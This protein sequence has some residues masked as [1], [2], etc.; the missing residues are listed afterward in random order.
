M[1]PQSS[2]SSN[3]QDWRNVILQ[4]VTI[5]ENSA[6]NAGTLWGGIMI[7]EED[8]FWAG[9]SV[10]AFQDLNP[11]VE[12]LMNTTPGISW[13]YTESFTAQAWSTGQFVAITGASI[14]APQVAT[15]YMLG[16][17]NAWQAQTGLPV[18]VTWSVIYPQPYDTMYY[19]TY[20]VTGS[21][22]NQWGLNL[23]NCFARTASDPCNDFDHDGVLNPSD[24]CISVANAGQQNTDGANYSQNR[25]GQDGAG[26]ACDYDI[27]GDGYLNTAETAIGENPNSYCPAMRADV[28][29]DR[30][31]NSSDLA[32][33][34]S[35]F[36]SHPYEFRENQDGAP[37]VISS[38]DLLL[39]ASR[40]GLV[41]PQCP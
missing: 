15:D 27:D 13:F 6:P 2:C 17:A 31:V 26:D 33:I 8:G 30:T 36:G 34:A 37:L 23:S 24:N 9:D 4:I 3:L 22:Y 38:V 5:V 18:L 41:A 25:A 40:F 1:T 19:P 29:G 21:P 16:L 28:R 35:K 10:T 39:A 20:L 14:P 12:T 7:D 11:S 32:L